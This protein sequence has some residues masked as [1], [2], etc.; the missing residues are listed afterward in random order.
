MTRYRKTEIFG[1]EELGRGESS[2]DLETAYL[3]LEAESSRAGSLDMPATA[4]PQRINEASG[5]HTS[6]R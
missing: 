5:P 6:C 1:L 4:G 3:T 2:W